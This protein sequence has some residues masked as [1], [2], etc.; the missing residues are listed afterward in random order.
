MNDESNDK[1]LDSIKKKLVTFFPEDAFSFT[2]KTVEEGLEHGDIMVKATD[3]LPYLQTALLDEKTLE[4]ELDGMPR[5][6]FSK[7]YDDP[8]EMVEEEI[9]GETVQIPP[10]YNQGDYLQRMSHLIILPLEPGM[11]NLSMRHSQQVLVRLF[12]SSSAIELGAFFDTTT[13]VRDLP[14][15]RLKYPVIGRHVRGLRIFRAKVPADM[16]F[17]IEIKG[18][19]N[20]RDSIE[21]RPV[22]ISVKGIAFSIEKSEQK[23]FKKDETLIIQLTINNDQPVKIHCTVRH[24]SKIRSKQSIEYLCGVEFDLRTRSLA[25]AIESIVATVQRAHL[26]EL[27]DLSEESGL[28][29]VL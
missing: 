18:K 4:V 29:L 28:K 26:K 1:V 13:L 12:T 3:I 22:D 14:V 9:D 6:Y 17:S 16:L 23:L 11:G 27:S 15:L 2:R 20:Q 8:P 25:S 21:T 10:D 7:V 5:V 19:Q 24:V